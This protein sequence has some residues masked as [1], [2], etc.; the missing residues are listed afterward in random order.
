M[1]ALQSKFSQRSKTSGVLI[2]SQ[3]KGHYQF[4]NSLK[5]KYGVEADKIVNLEARISG[6]F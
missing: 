2:S 1:D 6:E 3:E 4:L 5:Q